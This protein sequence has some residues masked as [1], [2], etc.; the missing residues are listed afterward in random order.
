MGRKRDFQLRMY[1]ETRLW[2]ALRRD[3]LT[4]A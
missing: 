1:K 3:P 4:A 2:A